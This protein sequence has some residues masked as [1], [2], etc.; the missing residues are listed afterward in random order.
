[1]KIRN[2]DGNGDWH[3]GHGRQDYL[4]DDRAINLNLNSRLR[5]FLNDCFWSMGF[6]IDWWNLLGGKNPTAQ[7]GIILQCRTMIANS[8]GVVRINTVDATTDARTRRLTVAYSIDTI[9]TRNLRNAVTIT[10]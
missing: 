7:V 2:T 10:P 8:Y 3:F 5:S 4:V 1:M 6:G 9:F